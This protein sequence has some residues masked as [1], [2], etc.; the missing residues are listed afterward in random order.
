MNTKIFY[1]TII[2]L[3]FSVLCVCIPSGFVLF[4]SFKTTALETQF[5]TETTYVPGN[6]QQLYK[7]GK[8]SISTTTKSFHQKFILHPSAE[9]SSYSYADSDSSRNLSV[10]LKPDSAGNLFMDY[11]LD[12]ITKDL[13]RIDT[14][15]LTRID[16]LKILNYRMTKSLSG[17]FMSKFI[18]KLTIA[19]TIAER[20]KL[21]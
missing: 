16:T 10:N 3:V 21:L 1:I 17:L 20:F 9:H 2:I 13:V 5:R 4:R 8:D 7:Q 14:I 11:F 19:K 12:I 18:I 6:T 15:F